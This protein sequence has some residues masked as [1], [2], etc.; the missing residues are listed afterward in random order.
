MGE[1]SVLRY[2]C[3]S[4]SSP[5]PSQ[6]RKRNSKST[7]VRKHR[8]G[9]SRDL[10]QRTGAFLNDEESKGVFLTERELFM[11]NDV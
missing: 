8:G 2:W 10:N 3:D 5:L 7:V 1:E 4:W 11:N 6:H 9:G